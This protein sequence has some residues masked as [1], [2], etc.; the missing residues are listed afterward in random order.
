M[1]IIL[2]GTTTDVLC[3]YCFGGT[4]DIKFMNDIGEQTKCKCDSRN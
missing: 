1:I 2:L 3:T 4:P